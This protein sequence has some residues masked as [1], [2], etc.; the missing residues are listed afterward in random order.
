[1]DKNTKST[2]I[3]KIR[4][5]TVNGAS[6]AINLPEKALLKH[7]WNK[8]SRIVIEISDDVIILRKV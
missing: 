8:T 4:Y 6:L 7:D 1:M 5:F 3:E 2:I